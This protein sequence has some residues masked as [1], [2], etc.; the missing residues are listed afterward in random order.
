[1]A[2][3]L[4]ESII[5]ALCSMF[6]G[7]WSDKYGRKPVLMSTFIGSFFTY[8]LVAVICF[9]SSQYEVDPWYY[10]LAYIPAALSGGN[11]ALITGVFC[12]ITDVTSE[13]NRAVK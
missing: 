6:I 3:S 5:P 10:I 9:L 8:T 4:I 2:K 11:C 12:Y 7:P 13:Q 1:M